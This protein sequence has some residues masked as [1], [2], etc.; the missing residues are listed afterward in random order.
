MNKT[1]FF[2]STVALC[3]LAFLGCK[4]TK[5]VTAPGASDLSLST[6]EV[7]KAHTKQS[8][9][10]KTLQCKIK[11]IY[12]QD[13]KSQSHTITMRMQK[14][15]V[16]WLNSAL[17][18]I[19]AKIT[20]EK[21]S[22]YNKLDNTY[23]D[24]DFGYLSQLLGTELDFKKVQNL[25]LGDALF[26]LDKTTHDMSIHNEAYLFQPKNQMRIFE[27]FYII[28][29]AHFKMDSQQLSQSNEARFLEIDY[30]SYQMVDKQ[31]VPEN[32]KIFVLEG[33]EETT[34]EMGFK[35][36][37]LNENLRYPFKIPS[38]FEEIILD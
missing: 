22:F 19:R 24:G 30:L 18:L 10:F 29:P 38:G 1:T 12:T 28:N 34:I 26:E 36:V 8:P 20:P 7:I 11:V 9:N 17:N 3:F 5:S 31:S 25:L 32:L 16:I 21:V 33:D 2:K 15:E 14:D 27:L 23:F 37:S 13:N 4:S 35:S 6:K